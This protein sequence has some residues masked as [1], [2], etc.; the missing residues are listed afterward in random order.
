MDTI[1]A[2]DSR[3][4]ADIDAQPVVQAAAALQPMLREYRE[5]I[6]TEQRLPIPLVESLRDAGLYRMV[7]PRSLGGSQVDP[8]TF[9][10]AVELLAEGC[11][12]VG[13]NLAN[14]SVGQLVTLGL[15]DEGVEELYGHRGHTVMAGTAVDVI[16]DEVLLARAKADHQ[17]RVGR[18]PYVCPLPADL[19]PPIK[20]SA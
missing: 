9:T 17:A 3:L 14:N 19:E 16:Q 2:E 15:P 6:E 4:P 18:T 5:Q 7:I 1:V 8:L 13:W 20:M 11:G 12:S 10:R